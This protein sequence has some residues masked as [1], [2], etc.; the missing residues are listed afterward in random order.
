MFTR[1]RG[2]SRESRRRADA[3][4]QP[5]RTQSRPPAARPARQTQAASV[6]T[7]R[8]EKARST[9]AIDGR[10][11]RRQGDQP[12]AERADGGSRRGQTL[13]DRD[14]A[15]GWDHHHGPDHRGEH[16][17]REAPVDRRAVEGE[18]HASQRAEREHGNQVLRQESDAEPDEG[19]WEL[20]CALAKR[21][22]ARLDRDRPPSVTVALT[23]PPRHPAADREDQHRA[24]EEP[25]EGP[26]PGQ[27]HGEE[28][29]HH[30]I[31]EGV[32]QPEGERRGRADPVSPKRR[33]NRRRAAGALIDAVPASP[34][35]KVSKRPLRSSASSSQR[36]GRKASTAAAIRR[37]A[38]SACQIAS[39]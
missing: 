22:L 9:I 11:D 24:H 27:H 23:H 34:A 28:D 25:G 33:R 17:D 16:D 32:R 1:A 3:P 21:G 20:H 36:R 14:L 6:S 8:P 38:A 13:Q 4:G 30:G 2:G 5:P 15:G 31:E 7:T 10:A 19:A 37:P 29:E 12:R 26:L 35:V 39:T 18:E